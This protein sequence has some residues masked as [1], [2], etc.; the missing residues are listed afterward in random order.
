MCYVI[1]GGLEFEAYHFLSSGR[2]F[3]YEH[4]YPRLFDT[5]RAHMITLQADKGEMWIFRFFCFEGL[6]FLPFVCM[7]SG[8]GKASYIS[9]IFFV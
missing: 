4:P 7:I 2:I 6:Q 1:F 8:N 9:S 3:S 5:P